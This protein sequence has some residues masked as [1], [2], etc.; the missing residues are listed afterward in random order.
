[1][2]KLLVLAGV[3]GAI[4]ALARKRKREAAAEAALWKEATSGN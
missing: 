4:F 3:G 2:K 1:M